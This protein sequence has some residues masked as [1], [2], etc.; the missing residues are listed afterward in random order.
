MEITGC[1]DAAAEVVRFLQNPNEGYLRAHTSGS[2]GSPK[3]ILLSRAEVLRSA[4]MT[5]RF[6]SIVKESVMVCPLS[7]EYIAGKMMIVRAWLA[8]CRL[9]ML[10]PSNTPLSGYSDSDI[11]LLPIVPSMAKGLVE[12]LT[13]NIKHVIVGGGAPSLS[14]EDLL[15]N[16]HFHAWATYGMTET[17]SHIA[18]RDITARQTSFTSLPGYRLST[19][20]RGCLV[21]NDL[22]FTND[23]VDLHTSN[24]FTWL[25][26]Y[27]NVIVSG[28]LK[29]HPEQIE[30]Q[31]RPLL[32]VDTVFYVTSRPSEQWGR[33]AVIVMCEGSLTDEELMNAA[34]RSLP[35]RIVPKTV[36]HRSAE[37]T[38]SGKLKRIKF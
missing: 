27:D 35:A 12:N 20:N 37:Y 26:R 6:F 16:A 31:L 11:T 15:A 24:Q 17:C 18:L 38:P 8:G 29:I 32:P 23:V 34:R 10:Q 19:D 2:T 25:G 7:A 9:H 5:N 3:P 22:I 30:A 21:I 28:G 13:V 4:E 1:D 14:Q 33:E 36:I